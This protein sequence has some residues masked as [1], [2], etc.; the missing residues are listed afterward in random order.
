MKIKEVTNIMKKLSDS[1]F[2]GIISYFKIKKE[3][4]KDIIEEVN[5]YIE[6]TEHFTELVNIMTKI[7]NYEEKLENYNNYMKK[8]NIFILIV[9]SLYTLF[10]TIFIPD[11]D[12]NIKFDVNYNMLKYSVVFIIPSIFCIFLKAIIYIK[13]ND[14]KK[15]I[16]KYKLDLEEL[17]ENICYLKNSLI[18]L[19]INEKYKI[20]IDK[21]D[22]SKIKIL[23]IENAVSIS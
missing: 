13:I 10:I 1:E 16:Q 9:I 18:L 3:Q 23:E 20:Y 17:R 5:I 12:I 4:I 7:K 8:I 14:V 19:K 2:E 22:L 15:K 21:E 6:K 11:Y